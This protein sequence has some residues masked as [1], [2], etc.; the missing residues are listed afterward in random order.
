MKINKSS[1]LQNNV[2]KFQ[3]IDVASSLTGIEDEKV[4]PDAVK[5]QITEKMHCEKGSNP[6][7]RRAEVGASDFCN[8]VLNFP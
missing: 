5:V 2:P 7:R 6:M 4:T 3:N 1:F 8:C